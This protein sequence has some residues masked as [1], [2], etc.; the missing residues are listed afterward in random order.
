LA[1]WQVQVKELLRRFVFSLQP[2][3]SHAFYFFKKLTNA[4]S[5]ADAT[6]A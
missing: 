2:G 4:S 3:N 1:F 6:H 5:G